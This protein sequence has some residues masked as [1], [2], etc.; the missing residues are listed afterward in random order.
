M[1]LLRH[2]ESKK[3]LK[4]VGVATDCLCS[5]FELESEMSCAYSFNSNPIY[6]ADNKR[7]D[8]ILKKIDT[9]EKII[10]EMS[11]DDFELI[12]LTDE[13]RESQNTNPLDWIGKRLKIK[14]KRGDYQLTTE[15]ISSVRVWQ[16]P[17]Y[18]YKVFQPDWI[19]GDDA[20]N[21]SKL[22]NFYD[23]DVE[24]LEEEEK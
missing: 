20:T 17:V 9:G 5:M 21:K 18:P 14:S 16:S 10:K 23:Y 7:Y 22:I 12:E 19:S 4:F 13:N 24:V 2:K 6:Y 15:K 8:V 11:I 3:Y 1:Y